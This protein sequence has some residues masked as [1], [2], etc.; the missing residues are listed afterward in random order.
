MLKLR[1]ITCTLLAGVVL[2]G[3]GGSSSSSSKTD[4]KKK[5]LALT[6]TFRSQFT[7]SQAK[8]QSTSDPNGKADAVDEVK[9]EYSNLANDL[10][11]LKAPGDAQPAQDA[12]VGALRKGVEDLGKLADAARARDQAK[13]RQVATALTR[14]GADVTAKLQQ[15]GAKVGG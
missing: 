3:C 9:T 4:Y 12:S 15:L 7:A 8:I 1:I 10:D 6:N 2:V 13:A 5:V 14:D 11:K